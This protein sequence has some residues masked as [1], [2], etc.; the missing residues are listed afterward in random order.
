MD[1][2][3]LLPEDFTFANV[4]RCSQGLVDYLKERGIRR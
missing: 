1:G 4:A 2:G 3:Q